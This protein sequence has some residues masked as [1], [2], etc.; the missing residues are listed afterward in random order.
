MWLVGGVVRRYII[1]FLILLIATPLVLALFA[2]T[3]LATSLFI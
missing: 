1:D 3:S 2:A